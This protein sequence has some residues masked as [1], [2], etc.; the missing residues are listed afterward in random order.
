MSEMNL[1]SPADMTADILYGS[2]EPAQSTQEANE[3]VAVAEETAEA[4]EGELTQEVGSEE[5]EPDT[6]AG[7]PEGAAEGEEIEEVVL[8]TF[9]ELSEHLET[10]PD[11]L[12]GLTI[13]QKVNGE[14]IDVKLSDALE[15]HRKVKAADT[16]L[17]E[18]KQKA[19]EISENMRQ[20][21]EA[22]NET[23]AV[24]GALLTDMESNLET[25]VSGV[26]WQQLR[27]DDPAAYAAKRQDVAD[28]RAKIAAVKNEAVVKAREAVA[29]FNKREAELRL[30]R[31]PE[32]QAVLLERLPEWA[33]EKKAATERAEVV[34]YL[35]QEGFD[36]SQVQTAAYNGRVL[37]LGIKAM[38]Y[39]KAT[40]AKS[41]IKKKIVKIPKVTKPGKAAEKAKP[42]PDSNDRSSVLYG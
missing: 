15:T 24:F 42:K 40:G 39:D 27:A 30:A 33:D 10:D 16:H 17:K 20:Q 12:Q 34:K 5:I 28:Q 18:A 41:A 29:E 9:E 13:K 8:S 2:P 37:A 4:A 31:L 22:L 14:E 19:N 32:E 25:E 11:F 6:D 3:E 23:V 38:R 1:K 35:Q 36:E 21:K 26:N 7:E